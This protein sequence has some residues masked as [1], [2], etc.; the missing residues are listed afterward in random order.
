MKI[1]VTGVTGRIGANLAAALRRDG[2]EVRGL[3]WGRDP[4]VEKLAPLGLE[5]IE[6][7]LTSAEDTR[8]ACE[9]VEAV[10]HLGAAFQ[11]GG[12][13]TTDEYFE[14]N[15]RGT[16][17]MLEAA[18][19]Q[20]P[21]L[22]HFVFSSTDAVYEKYVRGGMNEL[23]R[24]DELPRKP[25]GWYSI[26]KSVGEELCNGYH[27][28]FKTPVTVV[29]F[30]TVLSVDEILLYRQIA[31]SKLMRAQ[32]DLAP[33]WQES[34]GE[35]RLVLVRDPDG[36][37]YK[38][39][40]ADVRDVVHGCVCVLGK[41]RA[42]GETFQ[43]GSPTAFKWDELVPYLSEKTGVPYVDA[44]SSAIPTYYEY[45]LSKARDLLGYRPRYGF[46]EMVDDAIAWKNGTDIG[47]LAP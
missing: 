29:R 20:G 12:P 23:I 9:G 32:P 35:E 45:D 8:R 41:E 17:N 37:A 34:G 2:H 36:R 18:K 21:A 33:L 40:I 19:A 3:V 10:Y 31:L 28:S 27:R 15:V 44:R 16:F 26:S 42:A 14:I 22:K 38:K 7:S 43:L 5:L 6:G 24:E 46:R 30:P 4:R 1:L 47:V 13:F 25:K 39:H 11:G